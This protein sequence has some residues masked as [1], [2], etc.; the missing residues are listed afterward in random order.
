MGKGRE[1]QNTRW[2][3]SSTSWSIPG[4]Q[5]AAALSIPAQL[6]APKHHIP[7]GLALSYE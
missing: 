1:W 2:L 5:S 7:Y 3:M 4:L 6:L